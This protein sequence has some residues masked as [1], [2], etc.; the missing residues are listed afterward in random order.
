MKITDTVKRAALFIADVLSS[1]DLR[2]ILKKHKIKDKTYASR[3]A[4]KLRTTFSLAPAPRQGRPHVYTDDQLEAAQDELI[5]PSQPIHS[6]RAL[7][8]RLK[9][10]GELPEETKV[11]GFKPALQRHLAEQ[12]LQLGYGVRSKSQPITAATAAQRLKWCKDM[13][14]QMTEQKVKSWH[15]EDEKPHGLGGKSRCKW[16]APA[17]C[18]VLYIYSA[19]A[20][21]GRLRLCYKLSCAQLLSAMLVYQSLLGPG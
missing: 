3:L 12:G 5:K 14:P 8:H 1:V 13:R 4:E 18:T 9:G 10:D 11:R 20:F 6:T 19:P 16:P 15:F 7:V 21:L 17:Q 2:P